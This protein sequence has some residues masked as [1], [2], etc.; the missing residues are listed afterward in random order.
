MIKKI[1]KVWTISNSETL[2]QFDNAL[3]K[4]LKLEVAKKLLVYHCTIVLIY[5]DC[6]KSFSVFTISQKFKDSLKGFLIVCWSYLEMGSQWR[7]WG[8]SCW[9]TNYN[10]SKLFPVWWLTEA[11]PVVSNFCGSFLQTK[12]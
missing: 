6:W 5:V 12:A 2:K 4:L 3:W 9:P 10:Y 7:E 1:V 8:A 11:S